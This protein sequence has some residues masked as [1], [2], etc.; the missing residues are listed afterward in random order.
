MAVAMV[1][2]E[3]GLLFFARMDGALPAST[4]LA[5]SK[6]YT[7]AVL[8]MSTREL[9]LLAGPGGVLYGIQ[10]THNGKIILFGGGLPLRLEGRVAGAIGISG[11]SVEEDIQVTESVADAL[12]QMEHWFEYLKGTL[13][14][15][16]L[17][18]NRADRLGCKLEEVLEQM[19]CDLPPGAASILSGAILMAS[20][21]G[22]R[23]SSS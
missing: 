22:P 2:S 12:E 18:G 21:A 10:H 8:R 6:A 11:G 17:E 1:D 14:S 20:T 5:V 3:G 7:S 16:L 9:G 13:P 4:E 15:K 23:S 19:N